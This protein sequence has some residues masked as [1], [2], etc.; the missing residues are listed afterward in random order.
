MNQEEKYFVSLISSF[1]NEKAPETPPE[2]DWNE[3]YRLS[4]IHN[5]T[6]IT[7]NQIGKL[8]EEQMPDKALYSAFRQQIG[9]TIMNYDRKINAYNFLKK[10]LEESNTEYIFVKGIILNNFYPVKEFRTSGDIDVIIRDESFD[11]FKNYIKNQSIAID[12]ESPISCLS[13]E[14]YGINIEVHNSLYPDNK[15]FENI[16]ELAEKDGLEYKLSAEN[17]LL[18]ILCHIIK[19]FNICGAGIRMFM[20]I[21]VLIRRNFDQINYKHFFETCKD[22]NIETFV[23]S[24]LSL[25]KNWFSTPLKSDFDII[26]DDKIKNLFESEILSGGSFGFKKRNLGDFYIFQGIG[27]SNKNNFISKLKA[28]AILFFPKKQYLYESFKYANKHHYLLPFAWLHRLFGAVF[29][30]RKHSMNTIASIISS[31][32]K[33]AQYK[34][35]LNELEI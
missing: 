29:F 33:S 25:C 35:L 17:H 6:A 1:L 26:Y 11:N 30:R 14:T 13:F 34:M 19:H 22:L 27:N 31:D 15:Y 7:A 16:F 4:E 5:V 9:Q 18:Y 2:I 24:T 10:L 28:I 3:I 21:D 32:E 12:C 8:P 20:D 23:K